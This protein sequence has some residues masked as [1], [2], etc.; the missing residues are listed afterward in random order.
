MLARL[1]MPVKDC[2]DEYKRLAGP[3]FGNPRPFHQVGKRGVIFRK[4][5][6]STTNLEDAIKDVVR[7]RG[8]MANGHDDAMV[9][10]TPKGLCRA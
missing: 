6:F 7:R 4:N 3:V 1:R 9:F 2:I 8:E 5:K 10:R